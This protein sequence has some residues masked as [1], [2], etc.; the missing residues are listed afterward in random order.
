MNKLSRTNCHTYE[1]NC[2]RP[3]QSIMCVPLQ[4]GRWISE[5]YFTY[6]SVQ[7]LKILVPGFD[8]PESDP[9]HK[10]MRYWFYYSTQLVFH[11]HLI[12]TIRCKCFVPQLYQF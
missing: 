9:P 5:K 6:R 8:S 1:S 11:F 7:I 4:V 2:T 3:T 12:N 10:I